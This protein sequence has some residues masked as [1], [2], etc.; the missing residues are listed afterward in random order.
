ML[1]GHVGVDLSRRNIAVTKHTLDRTD[2]GAIHEQVSGKAMP[3]GMRRDMFRNACQ[4]RVLAHH[5]LNGSWC[6]AETFAFCIA[7]F[8]PAIP[9]EQGYCVVGA[10]LQVGRKAFGRLWA[11]EDWAVFLTFPPDHELAALEID[12]IAVQ[13]A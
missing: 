4:F 13:V 7:I 11:D 2:V 3:E 12:V 10:C 1:I 5:A 9:D 8:E 6:Q